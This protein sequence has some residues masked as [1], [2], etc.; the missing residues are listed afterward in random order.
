VCD[1]GFGVVNLLACIH[2]D[3]VDIARRS[4]QNAIIDIIQ[5]IGDR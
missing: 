1:I 4:I 2:H 3:D 5:F